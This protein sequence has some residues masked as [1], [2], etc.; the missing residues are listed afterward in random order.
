MSEVLAENYL[1]IGA[2]GRDIIVS[3]LDDLRTGAVMETVRDMGDSE[4][5]AL[6]ELTNLIVSIVQG[7]HLDDT[8]SGGGY[9]AN[10]WGRETYSGI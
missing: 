6:N 10:P 7:N 9:W 3:I 4:T 2:K 1:S 5:D 8:R